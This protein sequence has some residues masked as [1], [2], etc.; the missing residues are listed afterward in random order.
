[1]NASRAL[2]ACAG[3]C[4][5]ACGGAP[6]RDLHF[7]RVT[8]SLQQLEQDPALAP[9]APTEIARA[10]EAIRLMAQRPARERDS[11]AYVAERRVDIAYATAQAVAEESRLLQLEREADRLLLEAS[12]KDAALARLEAEKLRLQ[13]LAE[14]EEAQRARADAARAQAEIDQ[15]LLRAQAAQAQAEQAKRLADARA[16]EAELAKQEAVLASATADQLRAQV[17]DLATRADQ[18]GEVMVLGDFAFA[19]GQSSLRREAHQYLD[20]IVDFVSADP[21][22]GIRIEGHTDARGSAQAN[23]ALSLRRAQSLREALVARGVER[24]RIQVYGRGAQVPLAGNDSPAGRAKN[25]RVEV[26]LQPL[27]AASRSV[28]PGT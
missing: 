2:L 5:A 17:Q 15:S 18:R 26:I 24:S 20:K 12:R 21:R 19:P 27:D 13:G 8:L 3:I 10:R 14:S 16:E 22:R 6:K 28:E 25:R 4:L 9:L 11:A 1:M 23:Q 7:E